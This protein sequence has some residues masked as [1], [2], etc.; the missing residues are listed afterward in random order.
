VYGWQH[1]PLRGP[2][3]TVERRLGYTA[4]GVGVAVLVVVGTVVALSVGR[5][6]AH[7]STRDDGFVLGPPAPDAAYD[8]EL[9]RCESIVDSGD[10]TALGW[11]T[12]RRSRHQAFVVEVEFTVDGQVVAEASTAIGAAPPSEPVRFSVLAYPVETGAQCRV[13]SVHL[14]D[15]RLI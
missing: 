5:Y 12:N 10:V 13:A 8:V 2:P 9:D 4:L 11:L 1:T 7:G 3:S 15:E 6:L 14:A